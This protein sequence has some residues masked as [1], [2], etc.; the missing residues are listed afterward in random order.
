MDL[1]NVE[2]DNNNFRITTGYNADTP[3]S[4]NFVQ[5]DIQLFRLLN[6]IKYFL[7]VYKEEYPDTL[8]SVK[9][10]DAIDDLIEEVYLLYEADEEE[11]NLSDSMING[12]TRLVTSLTGYIDGITSELLR[13]M[14]RGQD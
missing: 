14:N 4:D 7:F 3:G 5:E 6:A 1:Y 13:R 9:V 8:T 12:L 11:K 10:T 2:R